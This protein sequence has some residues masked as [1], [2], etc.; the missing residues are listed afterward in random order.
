[1]TTQQK[2]E[3]L[4]ELA[5]TIN[6]GEKAFIE[7]EV[8]K[9]HIVDWYNGELLYKETENGFYIWNPNNNL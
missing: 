3:G 9:D 8:L 2:L 5:K 1:M 6:K 7:S 4:L